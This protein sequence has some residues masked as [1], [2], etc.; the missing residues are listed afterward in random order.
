MATNWLFNVLLILVAIVVFVFLVL[1]RLRK[2]E[3]WQ[4]TLTP[5]SSI[6]G[7]GFFGDGAATCQ[8]RWN[9]R[10]LCGDRDR[11]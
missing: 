11:F 1:P 6:I 7:S 8:Y 5:L 2:S 9:L 3:L 4:A 10:N